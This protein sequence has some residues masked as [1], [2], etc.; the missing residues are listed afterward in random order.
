MIRADNLDVRTPEGSLLLRNV[1]FSVG[2][3]E[4][5]ALVGPNGCGKSTLLRVVSGLLP[6]GAKIGLTSPTPMS[7]AY[8]PTRPLD[9]LLPWESVRANAY[10]FNALSKRKA[11][12]ANLLGELPMDVGY[13]LCPYGDIPAYA[14]SSGQQ[15][16]LAIQCA[17]LQRKPVLVA[18]EIFGTLAKSLRM[19][20]ADSLRQM[21][22][23]ILC[24][25]HDEDLVRSL[26]ARVVSLEEFIV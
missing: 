23:T 2:E 18:D 14:T 21:G 9:L 20:V 10:F 11:A 7:I 15:A 26:D 19:R 13:D 25:S 17:L 22:L 1:R 4:R 5:V 16:M 3:H 12:V 24:A 6:K 8:L